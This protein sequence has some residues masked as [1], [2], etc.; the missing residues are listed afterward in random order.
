M[1]AEIDSLNTSVETLRS[2]LD[3]ANGE[4]EYYEKLYNDEAES[5][6]LKDVIIA[7]RNQQ[8]TELQEEV[9]TLEESLKEGGNEAYLNGFNDGLESSDTFKDTLVTMFSSPTYIFSTIFDFELFGINFY[10]IIKV[11]I[12]A[13]VVI[14]IV[15][16]FI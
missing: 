15:K 6:A 9:D 2:K 8:I 14:F 1:R 7:A 3:S 11:I 4:A 10:Q 12:T 13:M 16:I 5:N